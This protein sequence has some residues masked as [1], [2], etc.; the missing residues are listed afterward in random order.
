MEMIEKLE[1]VSGVLI[2]WAYRLPLIVLALIV[3]YY[4]GNLFAWVAS[5]V[6]G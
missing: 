4:L 2:K 6:L 5:I 3:L 1:N